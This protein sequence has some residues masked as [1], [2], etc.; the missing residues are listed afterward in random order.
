MEKNR[1]K[2]KDTDKD[3]EAP[4]DPSF[5]EEACKVAIL[6]YAYTP[7]DNEKD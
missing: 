1:N 5:I 7:S 3:K 2:D 4:K 6:C